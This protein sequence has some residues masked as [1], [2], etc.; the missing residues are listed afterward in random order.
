M[1]C[2]FC[3][4]EIEKGYNVQKVWIAWEYDGK[5]DE[6][7]DTPEFLW[8][9]EEPVDDENLHVC[10]ECFLKHI[11]GLPDWMLKRRRKKDESD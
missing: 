5:N 6:Y 10:K 4:K 8:D 11:K 7:G 3:G 9:Y 1:H 2:E